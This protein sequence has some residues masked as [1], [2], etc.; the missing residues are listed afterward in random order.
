MDCGERGWAVVVQRMGKQ[1]IFGVVGEVS[2][3]KP[4]GSGDSPPL[5]E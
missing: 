5:V 3:S 4:P 1:P 2:C